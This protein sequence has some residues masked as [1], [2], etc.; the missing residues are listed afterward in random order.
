MKARQRI[1]SW[2]GPLLVA[3]VMVSL[4]GAVVYAD[5]HP[6]ELLYT[7]AL[8][9][10]PAAMAVAYVR[11]LAY[12]E[13]I[14]LTYCAFTVALGGIVFVATI[15]ESLVNFDSWI[16]LSRLV[17]GLQVALGAT[18]LVSLFRAKGRWRKRT[19]S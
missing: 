19:E 13:F 2:L 6:H 11:R 9:L 4:V 7:V 1:P 12:A 10:I 18:L 5:A 16:T 8:G 15:I 3:Q 17:L 14:L